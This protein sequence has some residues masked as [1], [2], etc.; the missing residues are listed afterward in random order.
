M[1]YNLIMM[2]FPAGSLV[3][4]ADSFFADF[5]FQFLA[6]FEFLLSMFRPRSLLFLA[7]KTMAMDKTLESSRV[8]AC[9]LQL[10]LL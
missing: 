9:S 10:A 3:S 4:S 8:T 7:K 6:F 1:G 2:L 5:S